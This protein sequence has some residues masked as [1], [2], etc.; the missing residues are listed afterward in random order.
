MWQ[1]T[2]VDV[3]A[4]RATRQSQWDELTLL[5][6]KRSLTG[7]EVDRLVELYQDT[8]ADLSLLR[9]QAPDPDEIAALSQRV[10]E[11][12]HRVTG[13]KSLRWAD[14]RDFFLTDFPVVLYRL[15][16]WTLTCTLL[17]AVVAALQAWWL[18]TQPA[19]FAAL[20]PYAQL[21]RYANQL[22][23]EY[24]SKDPALEFTSMVWTNNARIAALM[25]GASVTGIGPGAVLVLNALQ[26][27]QSAA[28]MHHFGQLDKFFLL[29]APHGLLELTAVFI[30]CA[31]GSRLAWRLLV[32]GPQRRVTAVAAEGRSLVTVVLGLVAVLGVAGLLEGFVTP[33]ALPSAL[34]VGLGA[35]ALALLWWY[36]LAAGGRA[37][38]AGHTGDLAAPRAG[39]TTREAG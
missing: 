23:A 12:R 7:P 24:Y 39:Y 38:R 26:V 15:R 4:V 30:A 18:A 6:A 35:G 22:F 3:E 32:P 11:A 29:I 19:A 16:W 1:G 17:F 10:A 25:V 37:A 9:S 33:A 21:E 13:V 36:T 31:A 8:A 5:R 28:I 2:R 14:L 34:K 20:G 27:G